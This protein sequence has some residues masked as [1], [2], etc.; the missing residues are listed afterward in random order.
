VLF[1]SSAAIAQLTPQFAPVAPGERIENLDT[2]KDL[3]KQY[4]ACTCK[5]GCYAKDL[6]LQAERATT[7]LKRKAARVKTGEKMAVVLDID[8]TSL[9]NWDEMEKAGF[10]YE[11]DV[12]NAWVESGKAPAIGGLL[13][14]VKEAQRLGM[15]VFFLTGRPE[16]QRAAT[17]RNLHNAGYDGWKELIL[18]KK[19]QESSTALTYKSNERARLVASGYEI[20]LNVGDQWSDLKGTPEAEYSVKYPDPFY[21]LK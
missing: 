6:D 1:C 7:F 5:C 10:A 3:A 19:G 15:D 21:F 8:E 13:R 11:K 2:L 17:E 12:F 4:H 9:S 16:S 18:R 20:V 14:I